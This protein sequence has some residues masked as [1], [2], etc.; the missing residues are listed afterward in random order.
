[1]EA[2]LDNIESCAS[3]KAFIDEIVRARYHTRH[4]FPPRAVIRAWFLKYLLNEPYNVG[5]VGRLQV[6]PVLRDICGFDVEKR[7]PS[8]STFSRFFKRISEHDTL[9]FET[10]PILVGF[11][12]QCG[13]LPEVGIYSAIDST[14]LE[15]HG[16]GKR[17]KSERSDQTAEFGRRT[18]KNKSGNKGETERYFGYS[19]HAICDAKYGIP[20]DF[21]SLLA[22]ES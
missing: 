11:L 16:R 19:I 20:L 9:L 18:T 14:D 21:M 17:P 1:M 22:F 4:G 10:L 3:V 7:V 2:T 6:S 15:A 5:L 13:E 12:S 8:E